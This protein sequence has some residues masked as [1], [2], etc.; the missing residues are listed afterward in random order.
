MVVRAD[1]GWQIGYSRPWWLDR[2]MGVL[3]VQPAR[4]VGRS[5]AAETKSSR[6]AVA[7]LRARW[8]TR[9]D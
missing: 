3:R 4:A 8:L 7:L 2:R 6:I 5:S 1:R 9:W